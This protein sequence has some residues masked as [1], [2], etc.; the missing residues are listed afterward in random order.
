M[1]ITTTVLYPGA[2]PV[3]SELPA[4]RHSL[5]VP[6]RHIPSFHTLF[7]PFTA[8]VPDGVSRVLQALENTYNYYDKNI[9][10]YVGD[11]VSDCIVLE[12]RV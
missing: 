6:R 7:S 1:S 8:L 4:S 2:A 5:L 11:H 12:W 9:I 10:I 3:H